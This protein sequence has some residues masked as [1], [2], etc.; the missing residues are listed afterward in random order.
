MK[1][2][3]CMESIVLGQSEKNAIYIKI[4]FLVITTNEYK[5]NLVSTFKYKTVKCYTFS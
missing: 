1:Q 3:V 2:V 4:R 5:G